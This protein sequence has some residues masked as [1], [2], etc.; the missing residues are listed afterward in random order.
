MQNVSWKYLV[1]VAGI[2]VWMAWL[3]YCWHPKPWHMK[4]HPNNAQRIQMLERGCHS[5]VTNDD[6]AAYEDCLHQFHAYD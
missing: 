2:T 5:L 6:P 3:A 4:S 1:V